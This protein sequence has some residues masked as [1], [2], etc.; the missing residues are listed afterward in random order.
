MNKECRTCGVLKPLSD[1]YPHSGMRDGRLNHCKECKKRRQSEFRLSDEGKQYFRAYF[2]KYYAEK[3][4]VF[5]ASQARQKKLHPEKFKARAAVNHAL[6]DKRLF[7]MP[8]QQCGVA[9]SE[10]HHPDYSRPLDVVWLC[11]SHHREVHSIQSHMEV[12]A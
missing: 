11:R 12:G 8:C 2:Q 5:K 9:Q 10:A 6:R 7:R 4:H 1:Y 3:A